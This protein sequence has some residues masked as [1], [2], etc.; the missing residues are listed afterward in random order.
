M[1]WVKRI[2]HVTEQDRRELKDNISQHGKMTLFMHLDGRESDK[3]Q[4]YH[5]VMG[6]V[7]ANKVPS[8][9][10]LEESKIEEVERWLNGLN[11][12]GPVVVVKTKDRGPIPITEENKDEEL[13]LLAP[14]D[15]EEELRKGMEGP[16]KLLREAGVKE[17]LLG[18][19]YAQ[20]HYVDF[21]QPSGVEGEE[22]TDHYTEMHWSNA[23]MER[24][25]KEREEDAST[26]EKQ[27][28]RMECVGT[29]HH[30]LSRYAGDIK[31]TAPKEL[32]MDSRGSQN[33]L[34]RVHPEKMEMLKK[35]F[36][37]GVLDDVFAMTEVKEELR[38]MSETWGEERPPE[39]E[40]QKFKLALGR[41]GTM[42]TDFQEKHKSN[43]PGEKYFAEFEA[44]LAAQRAKPL[45]G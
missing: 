24:F 12:E 36:R 8:I 14:E 23:E 16:I 41:L 44:I 42:S 33:K 38:V 4:E 13:Q 11:P 5:K 20:L 10:F 27:R 28:P 15:Y 17:L 21:D 32:I 45:R 35:L 6:D 30:A 37:T 40:L 29:I 31:L 2:E 9:V 25:R 1:A 19:K 22:P 34:M 43:S 3:D 26:A 18:G 7:I 39:E